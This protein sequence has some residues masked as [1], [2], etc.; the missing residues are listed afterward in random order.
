MTAATIIQLN[1]CMDILCAQAAICRPNAVKVY[2]LMSEP[3]TGI[4]S[5]TFDP[6]HSGHI[7][8]ALQ[9][10]EASKLDK[11]CFLPERLP[12]QKSEAEHFGHRSA[13]IARAIRPH[14][15]L[16]LL[17]LPD[18]H[19]TA[20]KTLPK[21][22]KQF[23]RSQLVLLMGSDTAISLSTWPGIEQLLGQCE[24]VIG[25]RSNQRMDEVRAALNSLPM[26][27]KTTIITSIAPD[28]NS[29]RIRRALTKNTKAI[30]LLASVAGYARKKWLYVSVPN[31]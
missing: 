8:F 1:R 5:G 30:G 16:M 25:L 11:V 12:R 13:M 31:K 21:L 3:R 23:P 7:A 17:E 15:K 2:R 6:V 10:I 24:L 27:S 29:A 14:S 26:H 4:F 28:V 20:Q 19:F 18:V 22:Q 9:A